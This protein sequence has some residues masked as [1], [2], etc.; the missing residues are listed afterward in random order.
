MP[1]LKTSANARGITPS[2]KFTVRGR[3]EKETAALRGKP[4][5]AVPHFALCGKDMPHGSCG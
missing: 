5:L 4:R 2:G 3:T 1:K